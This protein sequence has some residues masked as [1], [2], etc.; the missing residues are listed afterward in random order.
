MTIIRKGKKFKK[1]SNN[2][3]NSK[4]NNIKVNIKIPNFN[5]NEK[6]SIIIKELYKI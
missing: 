6:N 3:K 4:I 5:D 2:N 1:D